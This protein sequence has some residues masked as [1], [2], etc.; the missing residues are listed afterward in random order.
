MRISAAQYAQVLFDLIDKKSLAQAKPVISKVAAKIIAN[1]DTRKLSAIISK[2]VK[3]W[4]SARGEAEVEVISARQL[5]S[6]TISLL[7][8]YIKKITL[9]KELNIKQREDKQLIGG[10]VI[11][12]GD[13]VLDGSLK[14]RVLNLKNKLSK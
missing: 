8:N 13:K 6:S 2:F 3:I 5:D 14:N 7:K 4:N 11:K 9:A 10:V 12:Y 1:R